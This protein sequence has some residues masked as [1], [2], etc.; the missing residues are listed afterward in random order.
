MKLSGEIA[1]P[2]ILTVRHLHPLLRRH[3]PAALNHCALCWVTFSRGL[4][5]RSRMFW[6]VLTRRTVGHRSSRLTS[7]SHGDDGLQLRRGRGMRWSI[8]EIVLCAASKQ[9]G[10]GVKGDGFHD[11]SAWW[12][13]IGLARAIQSECDDDDSSVEWAMLGR[14]ICQEPQW[15]R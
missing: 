9:S 3:S 5:S 4:A 15:P 7:R 12:L 10:S 6:P 11:R 2:A 14:T 8:L 13:R 1:Q